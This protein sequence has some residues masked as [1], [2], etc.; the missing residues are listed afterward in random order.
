M[1]KLSL[2]Q[3]NQKAMASRYT[4]TVLIFPA[5]WYDMRTST[6]R[7]SPLDLST[8]KFMANP[9]LVVVVGGGHKAQLNISTIKTFFPK[10][11]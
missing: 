2:Q 10:T 7:K 9:F 8:V 5:S 3:A 6:K 11:L 4:L 1:H